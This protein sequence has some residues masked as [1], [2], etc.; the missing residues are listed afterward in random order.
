MTKRVR[1]VPVHKLHFPK[2]RREDAK[3]ESNQRPDGGRH[4]AGAYVFYM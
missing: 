1:A 4:D 2:I 3:I